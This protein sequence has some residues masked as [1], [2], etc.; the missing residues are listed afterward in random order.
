MG[1][2]C[3]VQLQVLRQE[4]LAEINVYR[5]L[6]RLAPQTSFGSHNQLQVTN[7]LQHISKAI[8]EVGIAFP[9]FYRRS[10]ED[11][12]PV[13]EFPRGGMEGD[14]DD[15][16][17][18]HRDFFPTE[19]PVQHL[20]TVYNMT[21]LISRYGGYA[22]ISGGCETYFGNVIQLLPKRVYIGASLDDDEKLYEEEFLKYL[23]RLKESGVTV[24][25]LPIPRKL[26]LDEDVEVEKVKRLLLELP[27][28]GFS[29]QDSFEVPQVILTVL[30]YLEN[31]QVLDFVGL[32]PMG[33]L[34]QC[35]NATA[36][37]CRDLSNF[38]RGWIVSLLVQLKDFKWKEVSFEAGVFFEDDDV[39]L[40]CNENLAPIGWRYST[41]TEFGPDNVS[42]II[43]R[44]R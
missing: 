22:M 27:I 25:M 28:K 30:P 8:Y 14:P 39:Q 41:E 44:R 10:A 34:V 9:G 2:D 20:L 32:P 7:G 3:V 15:E 40:L 6:L 43:W 16:E 36:I 11:I 5:K 33:L 13:F 38:D 19:I 31:L 12:W 29:F 35:K 17:D 1:C 21:S 37:R 24:L 4:A 18:D 42:E 26:H 23:L